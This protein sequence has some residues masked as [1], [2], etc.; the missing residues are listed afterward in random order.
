MQNKN[1]ISVLIFINN[2]IMHKR[3]LIKLKLKNKTIEALTSAID[4]V[5]IDGSRL[6]AVKIA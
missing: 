2:R 1:D 3:S 4:L 6:T 5:M